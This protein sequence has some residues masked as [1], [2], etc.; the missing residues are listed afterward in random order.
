MQMFFPDRPGL[1]AGLSH[2]L[3]RLHDT[4]PRVRH[5]FSPAVDIR[6]EAERFVVMA[7]LPGVDAAAIELTVEGDL[8]TI[9]GERQLE[10]ADSGVSVQRSEPRS[11]RFERVFRLPKTAAGDGVEAAYRRGVLTITIPK[12]RE[13]TPYRIEV[14]Q[15]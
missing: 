6:E 14:T 1:I 11:G 4:G 10:S 2:E 3:G 15:H 7:D 5:G 8:L 13:A 12:A 9:R